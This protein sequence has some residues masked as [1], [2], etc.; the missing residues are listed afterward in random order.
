MPA[1]IV[2]VG[3]CLGDGQPQAARAVTIVALCASLAVGGFIGLGFVLLRSQL[4]RM[5][6]SD[7][8][9]IALTEQ[10][11]W[12]VGPTYILLSLFFVSVATLEGQGRAIALAISFLIGAWG[13]T[14]PTSWVLSHAKH[15]GLVGIWLGLVAGYAVITVLSSI[16]CVRSDWAKLSEDAVKRSQDS[17]TS[18]TLS[19]ESPGLRS[20]LILRDN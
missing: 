5:F 8:E 3:S 12:I 15:H 2:R 9:V 10:L 18:D 20:P 6:S 7:P 17:K 19:D 11:C 1:T 4:G 16:A 13:V 14:V